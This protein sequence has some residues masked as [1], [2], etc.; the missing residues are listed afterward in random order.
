LPYSP[1]EL[2]EK[3]PGLQNGQQ[4]LEMVIYLGWLPGIA[5]PN[6]YGHFYTCKHLV[7][8]KDCAIYL[9][10]PRMCVEYPYRS[11]CR[12]PGCTLK[13]KGKKERVGTAQL[14]EK[15]KDTIE[16]IL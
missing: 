8:N 2:K 4:V 12:Y 13:N 11:E 9:T 10:R 15:I 7:D 1:Q 6:I 5:D 3:A 14:K 16:A